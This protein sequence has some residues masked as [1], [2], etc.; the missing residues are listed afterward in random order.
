MITQIKLLSVI[1]LARCFS[2][3][4]MKGDIHVAE[5]VLE[6]LEDDDAKTE[7]SSRPP[8]IMGRR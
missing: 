3:L 1:L 8:S 2:V 6:T 7:V 4:A 5:E